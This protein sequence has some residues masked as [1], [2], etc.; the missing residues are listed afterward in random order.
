MPV[1]LSQMLQH[2]G[3]ALQGSLTVIVLGAKAPAVDAPFQSLTQIRTKH[4]IL[5]L[6]PRIYP[7]LYRRCRTKFSTHHFHHTVQFKIEAHHLDNRK[8]ST[9][10]LEISNHTDD[11]YHQQQLQYCSQPHKYCNYL[12]TLIHHD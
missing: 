3:R 8:F 6:D 7:R 10:P 11:Y 5:G 9:I 4:V 1:A 2:H 12:Y